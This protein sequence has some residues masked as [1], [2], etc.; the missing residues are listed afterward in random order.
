MSVRRRIKPKKAN[1]PNKSKAQKYQ[2]GLISA[3]EFRRLLTLA[4]LTEFQ[5]RQ[6]HIYILSAPDT[7]ERQK[8]YK[9]YTDCSLWNRRRLKCL[10]SANNVC[11]VC[12]TAP[13][14]QAHHITYKRLGNEW[15]TDLLAICR[16]CHGSLHANES[17]R[18]GRE[19]L[20][21]DSRSNGKLGASSEAKAPTVPLKIQQRAAELKTERRVKSKYRSKS[22]PVKA[23]PKPSTDQTRPKGMPRDKWRAQQ[24]GITL[25]ELRGREAEGKRKNSHKRK[26]A[27]GYS[28]TG[29][30]LRP[31]LHALNSR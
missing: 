30:A 19:Q 28:P 31:D 23:V 4:S 13:A 10:Q 20:A 18:K 9:C 1:K 21:L 7:P 5:A 16:D 27:N 14:I 25:N 12:R 3:I 17:S 22:K 6:M 8:R 26:F 24:A 29:I 2:P 11:E 15:D